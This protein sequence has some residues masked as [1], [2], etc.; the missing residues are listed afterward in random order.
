[1]KGVL[2]KA[3]NNIIVTNEE[4]GPSEKGKLVSIFSHE[5]KWNNKFVFWGIIL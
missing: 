1:M 4:G 2:Y 3:K 5:H